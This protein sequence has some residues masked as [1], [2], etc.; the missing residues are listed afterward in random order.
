MKRIILS[1]LALSMLAVPAAQAQSRSV[2]ENQ[3]ERQF[4]QPRFQK[5]GV[6]SG[7]A[8]RKPIAKQH[9]FQRG[10]RYTNWKRQQQ[11]RDWQRHG[12]RRPGH[13]QQWVRVG[14]DYL[15]ITIASGII[16]GL[17]AGR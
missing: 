16:A 5:P 13:G 15:L 1:A 3:M 2:Y 17:I 12:L 11:V 9:R 10:H 7:H 6:R 8:V 14:N 4:Q